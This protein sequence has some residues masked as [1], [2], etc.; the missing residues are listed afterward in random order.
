MADD[1]EGAIPDDQDDAA[2]DAAQDQQPAQSQD[3]GQ[4]QQQAPDQSP[5]ATLGG[6][7]PWYA[8]DNGMLPINAARSGAKLVMQY[9]M[10]ADSADPEAAAKFAHGAKVEHPGVSDDDANVIAVHKATELGGPAAGWAMVQYNRSAYDRKQAFAK[11]ALNGIDGKTGDLQAAAQAASQASQNVLDGST[12]Q[13]TADP[14]GGYVTATV[15]PPG[16]NRTVNYNLTPQQFGQYLDVG[17]AGQWDRVMSGG[18]I[19]GALQKIVATSRTGAN[20]SATGQSGPQ[21][22]T[23]AQSQENRG[24]KPSSALPD[25]YD[26]NYVG[27]R[28]YPDWLEARADARFGHAPGIPMLGPTP[29]NLQDRVDWQDTQEQ[30]YETRK[31]S[32]LAAQAKAN[33]SMYSAGVREQGLVNAAHERAG[34]QIGAATERAGGQV[35]AAK[36]RA[37]GQVDAAKVTGASRVAAAGA[38][39]KTAADLAASRLL[40]QRDNMQA[41]ERGK[42]MR[43]ELNNLA[44]TTNPGDDD[45]AT[46]AQAIQNKY[47]ALP[48]LPGQNTQGA[49]QTQVNAGGAPAQNTQSVPAAGQR[50]TGQVY[51]TPKGSFRWMGNGW[52]PAQ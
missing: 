41:M 47:A 46:K 35:G 23:P 6:D 32:I 15:K 3:Q 4:D 14:G 51:R 29:Q 8:Q 24:T 18:G 39:A 11:A 30:P 31:A 9:L 49:P 28:Q 34:G 17:G 13:F 27:D 10:G 7:R 5:P 26:D 20:G 50:V 19:P 44:R 45:Y 16:S 12:A 36:E 2:Q 22:L 38:R 33:A 37:G 52:Q 48:P 25:Q 40:A 1:S 21:N 42:N 43:N